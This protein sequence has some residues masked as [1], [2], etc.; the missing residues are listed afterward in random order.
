MTSDAPVLMTAGA[1]LNN[2]EHGPLP[3][4][5]NFVYTATDPVA[6]SMTLIAELE[7]GS[8][9]MVSE[10]QTWVFAR[11]LLDAALSHGSFPVGEGDVVITHDRVR[12]VVT[13]TL[14]DLHGVPHQLYVDVEPVVEFLERSLR[15]VP[16]GAE[17]VDVDAALGQ[18]LGEQA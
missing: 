4:T 7:L 1:V 3:L 18:L 12:D 14:L 8:G 15:L 10:Q 9:E 16:T 5:A 17:T 11:N 6:V 2:A 13:F